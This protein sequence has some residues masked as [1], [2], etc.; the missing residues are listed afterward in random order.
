MV[1]LKKS[2]LSAVVYKPLVKLNFFRHESS[3][4]NFPTEIFCEFLCG[5]VGLNS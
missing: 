5:A 1:L 4:K 2:L 3:R